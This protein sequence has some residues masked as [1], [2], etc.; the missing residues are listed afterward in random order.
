MNGFHESDALTVL[1]QG[2][3]QNKENGDQLL[4]MLRKLIAH[5]RLSYEKPRSQHTTSD[6][7]VTWHASVISNIIRTLLRDSTTEGVWAR[8]TAQYMDLALELVQRTVQR[9]HGVYDCAGSQAERAWYLSIVKFICVMEKW[10]A[11]NAQGDF[12]SPT[13]YELRDNAVRTAAVVLRGLGY[14][15]ILE[16]RETSSWQ[17]LRQLLEESLGTIKGTSRHPRVTE[18]KHSNLR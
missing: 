9:L 1:T 13:P 17:V 2:G 6:K 16:K 5:P 14:D 11:R 10:I 12:E 15:I 8:N 7:T 4:D 3:P 18:V